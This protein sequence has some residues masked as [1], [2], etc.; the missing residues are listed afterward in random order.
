MFFLL[1]DNGTRVLGVPAESTSAAGS[2]VCQHKFGGS[3][4]DS[5]TL[6]FEEPV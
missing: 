1:C 2:A 3:N 4:R 6:E 5:P